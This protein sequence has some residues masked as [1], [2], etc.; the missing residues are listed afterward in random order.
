VEAAIRAVRSVL[1]VERKIA[2][3]F[4]R[5][6]D[7]PAARQRRLPYLTRACSDRRP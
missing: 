3:E 7:P 6:E 4:G 1:V 2:P 5:A